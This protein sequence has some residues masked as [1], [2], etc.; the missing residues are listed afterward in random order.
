MQ[1]VK[2][3]LTMLACYLGGSTSLRRAFHVPETS[4]EKKKEVDALDWKALYHT[5]GMPPFAPTYKNALSDASNT[6]ADKW[7]THISS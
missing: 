7:I 6:L 1:I 5:Q 2:I 3:T 4:A